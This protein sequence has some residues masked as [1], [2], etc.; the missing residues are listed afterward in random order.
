MTGGNLYG[1]ASNLI[2]DGSCSGRATSLVTG[3]PLLGPLQDNGGPTLTH[4]P[5]A[6]SP[7]VNATDP[8]FFNGL[9]LELEFD[10]RGAG[11]QRHHATLGNDVSVIT[12]LS[13]D[14]LELIFSDGFETP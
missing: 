4:L 7:A 12:I 2:N 1:N 5:A 13:D 10:Q 6:D 14:R 9:E 8:A 3:D 11:Y